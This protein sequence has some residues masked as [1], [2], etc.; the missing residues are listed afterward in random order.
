MDEIKVNISKNDE[1]DKNKIEEFKS[2]IIKNNDDNE[3]L[4]LLI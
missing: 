1:L 2:Y 3:K 4:K